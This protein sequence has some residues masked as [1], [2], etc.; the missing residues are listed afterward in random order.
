MRDLGEALY[1]INGF[2]AAATVFFF[3]VKNRGKSRS[4]GRFI[5]HRKA[6]DRDSLKLARESA[7]NGDD[8]KTV[9][10]KRSVH[11]T[12]REISFQ[13]R[14]RMRAPEIVEAI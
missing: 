4:V 1:M 2:H 10:S 13:K 7:E 8:M 11:R 12:S 5:P 6:K 14:K 9:A 3:F